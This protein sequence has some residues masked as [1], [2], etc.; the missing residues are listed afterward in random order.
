MCSLRI[1]TTVNRIRDRKKKP[2]FVKRIRYFSVFCSIIKIIENKVF[3]HNM[4]QT[5]HEWFDDPFRAV[6]KQVVGSILFLDNIVFFCEFVYKFYFLV[7]VV[8]RYL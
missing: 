1:S 6:V 4:F 7:I 5:I 8:E 3:F 2:G